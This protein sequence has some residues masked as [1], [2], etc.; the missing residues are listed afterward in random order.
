VVLADEPTGNLDE[1]SSD[2]VLGRLR[3]EAE[4]GATVVIATHDPQ[5]LARCD[6]RV[7]L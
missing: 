7:D 2:A 3:A 1:G 6:E 5:V 4:A